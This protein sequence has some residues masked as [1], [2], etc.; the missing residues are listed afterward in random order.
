APPRISQA[1]GLSGGLKAI[2]AAG[3]RLKNTQPETRTNA[4]ASKPFL[5]FGVL[6][7]IICF[8]CEGSIGDPTSKGIEK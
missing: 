1:V 2:V 7:D 4:P 5:R 3:D 6:A 8:C